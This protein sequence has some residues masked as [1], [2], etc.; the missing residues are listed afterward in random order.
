MKPDDLLKAVTTALEDGKV[1]DLTV[2]DVHD[3]TNIADF[4]V[5]GSG[6]SRR[7][8]Q[9]LVD[10]VDETLSSQGLEPLGREGDATSD[11]VLID[12]ADVL[13]HVMLPEARLYYDLEQLWSAPARQDASADTH[14]EDTQSGS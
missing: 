2:L 13:V 6:T 1:Q 8:L 9:S 14:S 12:Y 4:M 10:R 11:W 3:K 5:I 7:H